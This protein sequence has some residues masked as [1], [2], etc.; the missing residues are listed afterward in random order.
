M[1]V[2]GRLALSVSDRWPTVT[3]NAESAPEVI[4]EPAW[5]RRAAGELRQ[6][7]VTVSTAAGG[8]AA[9]LLPGVVL[10]ETGGISPALTQDAKITGLTH[11]LAVSGSHVAVLIGLLLLPFRRAGPRIAAVAGAVLLTVLVVVVG[12]EPS[13]LRAVVMGAIALV[14]LWSGRTRSALP[15]LAAA[16]L[17]LLAVDPELAIEPGF[18]LSVAAT[19]AIVV[20][21]PRWTAACSSGTCR[22]GG[23]RCWSCRWWP[24]SRPC[25]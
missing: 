15:A 6:R 9:G 21:A 13:V 11:L 17:V 16:V 14:A 24:I 12:A 18:A 19:A 25:R 23:R 20:L 7:F 10:G 4:A 2:R 3:V 1:T 22:P 8:E 5:W